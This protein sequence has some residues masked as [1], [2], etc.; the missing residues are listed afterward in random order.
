[1]TTAQAN[2]DIIRVM[3][4][5][6][7][8]SVSTSFLKC[9]TSVPDSKTW[10]EPFWAAF[11]FS[12]YGKYRQILVGSIQHAW[13][14]KLDGHDN[15]DTAS[16]ASGILGGYWAADKS[17]SWIKNQ[18]ECVPPADNKKV[19]FAKDI[20]AGIEGMYEY[21]PD[22][23]RHSFLIR[24]P[25][26][27]FDSWER[28]LNQAV[29][30]ES[31][32]VKMT[33]LPEFILPTG[34]FFKEQY[35][36][37]EHVKEHYEPNPVIIDTDDLLADPGR[38]LKAYCEQVGIPYSDDL[39]KWKPGRECMD[40]QWMVAKE[41]IFV[42]NFSNVHGKTFASSGFGKPTK[43]LDR[44]ELSDDVRHCSD[45]CMEY[46]EAMYANRFESLSRGIRKNDLSVDF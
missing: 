16:F 27:V 29:E 22:G 23:F 15:V 35:D 7:P 3:L 32:R 13:R 38:V 8:R 5:S 20:S 6:V 41:Q 39:L 37:Y 9:M 28:L 12:N 31:K 44:D 34:M 33:E 46:Y 43:V 10:H 11:S 14:D 26:K 30:D 1:M 36:L 25:Y 17:Y 40:K 42:Q 4:W 24:H 21:L 18:L 45:A 2:S 19:V